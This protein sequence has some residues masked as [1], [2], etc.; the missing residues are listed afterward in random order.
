MN[1][2]LL[3]AMLVGTLAVCP[4]GVLAKASAHEAKVKIYQDNRKLEL[5]EKVYIRN[6]RTLVP[7]RMLSEQLGYRVDWDEKKR[8]VTVSADD[9]QGIFQV[10]HKAF[11][12][13]EGKQVHDRELEAPTCIINERAYVPL[14][15]MENLNEVLYWDQDSRSIFLY[16]AKTYQDNPRPFDEEREEILAGKVP[17]K[18][19]TSKT[20]EKS[21]QKQEEAK[22]SLSSSAAKEKKGTADMEQFSFQ[23]LKQWNHY[24]REEKL[25][26]EEIK[27]QNDIFEHSD[28]YH[29]VKKIPSVT[30]ALQEMDKH[31]NALKSNPQDVVENMNRDSFTTTNSA[32][33]VIFI[34]RASLR[35]I[36]TNKKAG[37]GSLDY[38]QESEVQPWTRAL[39]L[40]TSRDGKWTFVMTPRFFAWTETKN[41]AS[42]DEEYINTVLEKDKAV[43]V[44]DMVRINDNQ[45]DMGACLPIVKD[46]GNSFVLLAPDR[47]GD[48]RFS[49]T[50]VEVS[51]EKVSAYPVTFTEER[52]VQAAY[53]FLHR[54][55]GWGGMN[56]ST[57]CSGL[58]NNVYGI[59]GI[60]WPRNSWDMEHSGLGKFV[61]LAAKSV[62]EKKKILAKSPVGTVVFMK[63]HV[64]IYVGNDNRGEPLVIH[65]HGSFTYEGKKYP[66]GCSVTN[67]DIK[68]SS[69][70]PYIRNVRSLIEFADTH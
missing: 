7:L 64:M 57:D 3:I 23:Q 42:G 6:E 10:D 70:V 45:Y 17:S 63:G 54:D 24:G 28:E 65:Q 61:D 15:A 69:G 36:P 29:D 16:E 25:S 67:L 59:F 14:R 56:G 20:K 34:K 40:H 60:R 58:V 38:N 5:Q 55:Y 11:H 50:P 41:I 13:K 31:L 27:R 9:F 66:A 62:E 47:D 39:A 68:N 19:I 52:L 2:K 33:K 35:R 51:K 53:Q 12:I 32:Q 44:Q 4:Q 46:K 8:Q 49:T 21:V 1:K 43:V 22:S 26:P 48:G 30:K 18:K 37:D